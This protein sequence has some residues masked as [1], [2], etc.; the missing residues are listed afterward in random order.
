[1]IIINKINNENNDI[2]FTSIIGDSFNIS[3]IY[4]YNYVHIKIKHKKKCKKNK[5]ICILGVLV[6]ENGLNIEKEMINWLLPEYDI[7]IVYQKNPG[8]LYEYP[9]LRFA[10]WIL[11]S[12]NKTILLYLN[13]KGASC[14]N[15]FQTFTRNFWKN[16]FTYPRNK[17]YIK[18]ILN[19]ETDVSLPFRK[20][21]STWFNGMFISKRTFDAIRQ[22]PINKDR[23]FYEGRLFN[24][25]VIRIKGII[26]DSQ[27]PYE[28]GNEMFRYIR[29]KK[30]KQ[31]FDIV[32]L[33]MIFLSMIFLIKLKID[34]DIKY[35]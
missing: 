11:Q 21:R 30:Y 13:T 28:I 12:L 34:Y 15:S 3:Q 8:I 5:I 19:N 18:S 17:I 10:Q 35:F 4:H 16:E 23:Y 7:Y 25:S 26:N 20:D 22:I 9:A 24:D 33:E 29:Q 14:Y 31:A 6:N 2:L 32:V 1:M 27:S